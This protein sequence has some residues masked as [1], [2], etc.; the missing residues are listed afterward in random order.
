MGQI[1]CQLSRKQILSELAIDTKL[2][3]KN[4]KKEPEKDT[5]VVKMKVVYLC[6]S[7]LLLLVSVIL[8]MYFKKR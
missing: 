8:Y 4:H 6:G 1:V 2:N 5:I 3:S 7:L